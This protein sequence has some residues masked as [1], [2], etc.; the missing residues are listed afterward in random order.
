MTP[1]HHLGDLIRN[2]LLL[3]PLPLVRAL[4]VGSLIALLTWVWLLPRD[5]TSPPG[6]ARRWDENLKLGATLALI[7][8]ILVYSLL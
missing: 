5:A 6:G 1:L 4:F 3:V 2:A 8:Q 7:I